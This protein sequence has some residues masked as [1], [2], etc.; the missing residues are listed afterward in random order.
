MN[1]N[2]L[3]NMKILYD[4]KNR[5]IIY[6]CVG[7]VDTCMYSMLVEVYVV[8]YIVEVCILC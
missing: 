4:L 3:K 1:Q 2:G 7:Y 5:R 8:I 6:I